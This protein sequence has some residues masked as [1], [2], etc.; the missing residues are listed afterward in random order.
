MKLVN[1]TIFD[2]G[3]VR[4]RLAGCFARSP[5]AVPRVARQR[6]RD[7]REAGHGCWWPEIGTGTSSTSHSVGVRR[8][9]PT[10]HAMA[11]FELIRPSQESA[12]MCASRR[13]TADQVCRANQLRSNATGPTEARM[14]QLWART[15]RGRIQ[16]GGCQFLIRESASG[17]VPPKKG[18]SSRCLRVPGYGSATRTDPRDRTSLSLA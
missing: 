8:A 1:E 17:P 6:R 4:G 13:S 7:C 2:P 18:A 3:L 15:Q 12:R 11:C 5:R 16:F 10:I 9:E 14:H